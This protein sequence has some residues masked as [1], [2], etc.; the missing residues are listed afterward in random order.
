MM[1]EKLAPEIAARYRYVEDGDF[2]SALN[3]PTYEWIPTSGPPRAI[4]LGI[5]GL[6]LHGR[7]YRVLARTFTLHGFGFV[8]FDMRGFGRCKEDPDHRFS[9]K[10]DNKRKIN[11]EK[12]YG[13][14]VKLAQLIRQKYPGV[15][16]LALG[17]SL[18]CTFCV[19]LAGEHPDLADGLI[20]S[21]P[22][23]KVNPKMYATPTDIKEGVKSIVR[24]HHGVDMHSFITGLVSPRPEVVKEMLDDPYILKE[25]PLLDL[26]ATDEF[27]AKTAKWGR[28]V[29]G[30]LPVLILQGGGDKCVVSK[31]V[32]ELMYEMP[33]TDQ[34]LRWLGH[35]GHLQ[36]ETTYMRALVIDAIGDWIN[37]HGSANRVAVQQVEKD[38][39]NVGGVLVR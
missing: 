2:T 19:R 18:G 32:T 5:H 13:D 35:F 7:R 8:S 25:V 15:P 17:E 29:S 3:L 28:T 1:G 39:E 23:V 22:A 38:I 37:D 4:V 11:H 10:E 36:L 24:P 6:T 34:T 9:S 30:T 27:V 33:S 26:L 14:I 21:A 12:S 16:I 31:D 20:L